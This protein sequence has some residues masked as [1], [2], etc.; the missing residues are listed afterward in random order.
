MDGKMQDITRVWFENIVLGMLRFGIDMQEDHAFSK[1][2]PLP[3]FTL[4]LS[5]QDAKKIEDVSYDVPV[6]AVSVG[7]NIPEFVE[8][9]IVVDKKLKL[10][11]FKIH[12]KYPE[13]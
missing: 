3:T 6:G 5:K 10:G 1:G 4:H 11:E 9:N 13:V 8:I 12:S 2:I 7:K